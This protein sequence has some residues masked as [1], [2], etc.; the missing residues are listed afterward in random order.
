MHGL[1]GINY[2]LRGEKHTTWSGGYRVATFVSGGVIPPQLRGTAS[3]VRLSIVDWYPTLCAAAGLSATD[4]A[5]DS[6][7]PP[8]KPDPSVGL[9]QDIYGRD[10]WPGLDGVD[11]WPV[12]MHGNAADTYAVHRSL[13]VSAQVLLYG[14]AKLLLGQGQVPDSGPKSFPSGTFP[15]DGWH[16][17]N[18]SWT[19][20]PQDWTCGLAWRTLKNGGRNPVGGLGD[21]EA[22]GRGTHYIPCLFNESADPREA[23]DTAPQNAALVAELWAELN[24]TLVTTFASRTPPHMLGPCNAQC[25]AAH[26]KAMGGSGAG[27][28][29]G[30]PGCSAG[31]PP[32]PPGPPP[33]PAS[34]GRFQ[35]LRN[36]SNC[37]WHPGLGSHDGAVKRL[38]AVASKEACCAGCFAT[39]HCVLA[40]FVGGGCYLHATVTKTMKVPASMGCVT[41]RVPVAPD[42]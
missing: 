22:W 37:T 28:I 27:P 3:N 35:P 33:P 17:A 11:I 14:E 21:Y 9:G 42:Q 40:T 32:S 25:A 6:P 10:A 1:A 19:P 8:E 29:C 39:S 5:D 20:P 31:P 16:E 15:T 34:H 18:G 30:V 41:G 26:W 4:C 24:A 38:E 2:P 12:L 7:T 23:V 36:A 13:A